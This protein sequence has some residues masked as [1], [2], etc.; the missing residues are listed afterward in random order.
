VTFG[1]APVLYNFP[2]SRDEINLLKDVALNS[3]LAL[4]WMNPKLTNVYKQRLL[5][6][7][8]LATGDWYRIKIED[9]GDNG[10]AYGI[11][12]I[13]R[14]WLQNAGINVTGIDPRTIKLFGN[15]G[16][17]LPKI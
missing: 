17:I 15:G 8:V 3:E 6:P 10:E 9:P 12:K 14:T 2:R 13:T 16:F 7:S 4:N 5:A 1:S 11:Y